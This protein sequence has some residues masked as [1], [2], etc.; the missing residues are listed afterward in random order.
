MSHLPLSALG[1]LGKTAD[2]SKGKREADIFL[3][4]LQAQGPPC[5]FAVGTRL[6]ASS[7]HP[8]ECITRSRAVTMLCLTCVALYISF[9]L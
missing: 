5:R 9:E 4:L 6:V 3:C 8:K 2:F 7:S 1:K